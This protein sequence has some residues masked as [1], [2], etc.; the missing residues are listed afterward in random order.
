MS[1]PVQEAMD[2]AK[3][4]QIEA[5]RVPALSTPAST[6]VSVAPQKL[7]ME[8][9]A[10]GGMT[11]DKWL[12]VNED[13]IKVGD[14]KLLIGD[15]ICSIDMTEGLGF[16]LKMAIKGGN[17]AQYAYTT[18]MV[19]CV[20]GGS[21]EA[22]Q[23]RIRALSPQPTSPYRSVDLPF[24]ATGDLVD[25]VKSV[26]AKKGDVLGYS[27]S[28]TNWANWTAFHKEVADA[29][30]MDTVVNVKLTAQARTNKNNNL[31]GVLKMELV[32]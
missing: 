28:T 3:A 8:S 21:W 20:T 14:S 23:N 10:G 30:L 9:M 6:A 17:P 29:G 27:T 19:N 16:I 18:D 13:G 5:A 15:V 12:K 31:W 4:A 25:M 2:R 7:S 24:T 1:D 32:K 22:A 11:V 26:V